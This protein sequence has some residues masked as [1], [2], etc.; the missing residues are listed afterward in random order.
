MST[1]DPD[2]PSKEASPSIDAA[3][4]QPAPDGHKP[5]SA[6]PPKGVP[7]EGESPAG[8]P[9]KPPIA[10]VR[11]EQ[12]ASKSSTPESPTT[13]EGFGVEEREESQG[14]DDAIAG[15]LGSD[16]EGE[17]GGPTKT[18]ASDVQGPLQ[19]ATLAYWADL[20]EAERIKCYEAI[21]RYF[22]N[23]LEDFRTN[24]NEAVRS[25]SLYGALSKFWRVLLISLTGGLALLNVLATSWPAD[26]NSVTKG[27]FSFFAA[28]YAVILAL[29]TN[30]ESFYNFADKKTS[31]RESREL[32]LDAYREFEMLRLTYVYPHGYDAHACFNFNEL[33]RRLVLKDLELR[34]KIMNL[35]TTRTGEG[36]V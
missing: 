3:P 23:L 17:P 15:G 11:A 28:I 16:K 22:H 2:N 19:D 7:T 9:P 14:A 31:T 26:W 5:L 12:A 13:A 25:Y 35:S 27:T 30:V 6:A 8:A 29:L 1:P 20:N 32:Y 10:I 34:R 24:A 36:K 21:E 33:Y 18:S 4:V